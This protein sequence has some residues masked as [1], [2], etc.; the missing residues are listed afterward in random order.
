[1]GWV[2]HG[3]LLKDFASGKNSAKQQQKQYCSFRLRDKTR[4]ISVGCD[5]KG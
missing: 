4:G 2:C 5:S 3:Q 1:M